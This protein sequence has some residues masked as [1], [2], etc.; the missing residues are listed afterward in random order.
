MDQG[1]RLV[2]ELTRIVEA[3]DAF[4]RAK[5]HDQ[6]V[7]LPTGDGMALAFFGDPLAAVQCAADISRALKSGS[8]IQ[9][10]MGI[11]SGPVYHTVD[12][13]QARNVAGG[14]IN[15][16]QRVMDCG[17][18][19]HILLSQSVADMLGQLAEWSEYVHDIGVMEVKHG[20]RVQ[21]F[22]LH[23]DDFGNAEPP[24]KVAAAGSSGRGAEDASVPRQK[25]AAAAA[26]AVVLLAGAL[27]LGDASLSIQPGCGGLR[28]GAC[29]CHRRGRWIIGSPCNAPGRGNHLR[30]R[31]QATGRG[32]VRGR[33]RDLSASRQSSGRV[34]LHR[35][36]GPGRRDRVAHVDMMLFPFHRD[37]RGN[38]PFLQAP[39]DL[40]IPETD[41]FRLRRGGG[42]GEPLAGVERRARP[43][44]RGGEGVAFENPY[45]YGHHR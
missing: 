34:P 1:A 30:R 41:G 21:V 23:G 18:D 8:E 37:E 4:Q 39:E 7:M 42:D 10:R 28:R 11:N 25:V 16:A 32:R 15:L 14:G 44:F 31:V 2:R 9:L 12:I 6:L 26:L 40:R 35:Q 3:T 13:N 5:R 22:S 19:G 33:L 24:R 17:D 45:D 36:R 29:P 38:E 43:G 27:Q 20:V